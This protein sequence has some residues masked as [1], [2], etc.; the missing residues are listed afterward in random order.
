MSQQ[1]SILHVDMDAFFASVEQ[2]DHP[3]LRGK[4]ILVGYDGPRGV[5]ATAS[6][7]ARVYGCRS[8]QP[9]SVAR[10]LCPQAIVV[11]VNHGR[12]RDIST[13]VFD[14]LDEF[15]P[16]V[17]PVSIDEAFIDLTG[18]ERLL[19]P[20]SDAARLLKQRIRET[21]ALTASVGV[22]PNKFLSKLA[23]DMQKPD[24]LVVIRA[25]DVDTILPPL[26][27]TKIW[28][29]GPAMAARL[30]ILG[31]TTI[32][33]LR[34]FPPEVLREQIGEEADHYLRLAHG[35]DDRPVQTDQGAKSVGHEQTFETNVG[36][37]E[38][39]RRV[40][41][42][43]AEYVARRLR[44]H[45]LFARTITLKIRFGDFETVTRSRTLPQP[46]DSTAELEALAVSIWDDWAK[47]SFQP[48][49]L[50]GV[51]ASHFDE[52]EGQLGL[53]ADPDREKQ[54]RIDAVADQIAR[55][56]GNDSIRRGGALE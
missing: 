8:A 32:A 5:V 27:V 19:G 12:Y 11:P 54:K 13:Q 51:T 45:K 21:T 41:I 38:Q 37:P 49:R 17:E 29:I 6:Y 9:M 20:A 14:I 10:R 1:R 39:I 56:F 7:E 24:G 46:S 22:A 16:V 52:P 42:E 23:S 18:T 36:S 43:Q 33:E 50:I 44:K 30:K 31:I 35:L 3:E 2:L 47:K 48:I 28:G 40:I 34:R 26:P 53:F 55:R 15:S 4:P 25:E